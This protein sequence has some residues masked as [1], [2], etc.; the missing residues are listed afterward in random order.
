MKIRSLQD[1]FPTSVALANKITLLEHRANPMVNI[2]NLSTKTVALYPDLT[3]EKGLCWRFVHSVMGAFWTLYCSVVYWPNRIKTNT[4]TNECQIML[5]SHFVSVQQLEERNDFYFGSLASQLQKSGFVVNTVLINH[6]R[7]TSVDVCHSKTRDITILPAFLSPF[8][9]TMLLL[10]MISSSITLPR[11]NEKL[12]KKLVSLARMAQFGSRALGEM[13]IGLLLER[14]ILRQK[15]RVILHTFEGHGWERIVNVVAHNTLPPVKTFGYQHA[16]LLPGDKSINYH[17]GGGADPDYFLASGKL[18]KELF[19]ESAQFP[20]P[21]ALVLGSVKT[22]MSSKQSLSTTDGVCLFAPEGV[23]EEVYLMTQVAIE[24]ATM[25]QDRKF[26]LRLHPVLDRSRVEKQLGLI[27]K[28]FSLSECSLQDDLDAASFVCYRSSTVVFSGIQAGVRPIFL[29]VDKQMSVNDPLPPDL[30]FRKVAN[31]AK[32]LVE[33]ISEMSKP[34]LE[35]H[36]YKKALGYV[37][38]YASA[39][40]A[41]ELIENLNEILIV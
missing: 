30:S 35:A 32:E 38:G 18:T 26:V 37:E 31:N 7:A 11:I 34:K 6:C 23:L 24:A 12:G 20:R 36:E 4:E 14:Q 8:E 28:N 39:F 19:L 21:A 9:E 1:F 5:V 25:Q 2:L 17:H 10:R 15:P 33:I 29:D 27:P 3:G 22:S 40:D 13:R 41:N 16:V